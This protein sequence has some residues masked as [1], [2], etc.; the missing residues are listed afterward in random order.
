MT[1]P[2]TLRQFDGNPNPNNAPS[3]CG[4]CVKITGPKGKRQS[5]SIYPDAGEPGHAQIEKRKAADVAFD[6]VFEYVYDIITT[7]HRSLTC[8]N[9]YIL[10]STEGIYSTNR[11]SLTED[12]LK[13]STDLRKI[14]KSILE[15]IVGLLDDRMSASEEPARSVA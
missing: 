9:Y 10:H 12:A 13:D 14:L 7:G 1:K 4:M 6:S 2:R 3:I 11:I 8:S 15:V 5:Q